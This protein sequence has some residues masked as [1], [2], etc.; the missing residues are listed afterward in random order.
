MATQTVT[1]KFDNR[2]PSADPDVLMVD[3]G[4]TVVWQLDPNNPNIRWP[5]PPNTVANAIWQLAGS[6]LVISLQFVPAVAPATRRTIQGTIL[7]TAQAGT[8]ESYNVSFI[9]PNPPNS[10]DDMPPSDA[11]ITFD[12]K[13][14]VKLNPLP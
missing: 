2:V 3:A 11:V 12:P 5:P 1:I 14:R 8:E 6:V 10:D 13:I 9:P 4:D 7:S